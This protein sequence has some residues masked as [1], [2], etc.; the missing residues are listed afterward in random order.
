MTRQS[1]NFEPHFCICNKYEGT[2]DFFHVSVCRTPIQLRQTVNNGLP[3]AEN[4][5]S[6]FCVTVLCEKL[7]TVL[8]YVL[9]TKL[10]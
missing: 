6:S 2:S 7:V 10:F 9:S 8:V 3:K 1:K 4:L 5:L